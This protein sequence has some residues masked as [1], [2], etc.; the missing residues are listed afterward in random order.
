MTSDSDRSSQLRRSF[1]EI[2]LVNGSV[3][4]PALYIDGPNITIPLAAG[5]RAEF[6]ASPRPL[7]LLA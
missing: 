6:T 4:D 5:E 7:R 2:R 3:G 1:S